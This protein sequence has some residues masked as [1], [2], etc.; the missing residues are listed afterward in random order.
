MTDDFR[1]RPY[2]HPKLKWVVRAKIAGKWVRKYFETKDQAETYRSQK[3][4]EVRNQGREA[5]EFPSWLRVMAERA[6]ARLIPFEKTIDDAVDFY[7]AHL[8]RLKTAVPIKQAI[9]ELIENRRSTGSSKMYCGDLRWRLA[10]FLKDHPGAS[11]ADFTTKAL[12]TWLTQLNVSA[13]TRNTFRRDLRTLF[14]F[15]LSRGYCE[16]NPASQTTFSKEIQKPVEILTID[17]LTNLLQASTPEVLPYLAIGAFAGLRPTETKRLDWS[18]VDLEASLLEVKAEKSKTAKRRLVKILPNL[19]MW[20][21]PIAKIQ[22]P[23]VGP[24]LR[25]SLVEIREAAGL[26]HWPS[27]A[28]RHSYASYHLANFNDAAALA[29]QMGH[30]STSMIFEHYREV[31][32]PKDAALYWEIKPAKKGENIVAFAAQ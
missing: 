32:K 23:V 22:G 1:I 18:E 29:L 10:R 14:S 16:K 31:V 12:D 9:E 13:V 5:V 25:W 11:T 28:L 4:I 3:N 19:K 17:Q 20:L 30:T 6:N 15:C 24:N 27:N 8:E 7:T 26:K 2:K 21:T